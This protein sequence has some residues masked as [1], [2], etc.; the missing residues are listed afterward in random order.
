MNNGVTPAQSINKTT[1]I[2]P[3]DKKPQK[4]STSDVDAFSKA[5]S[6]EGAGSNEVHKAD[7][8]QEVMKSIVDYTIQD[9][10]RQGRKTAKR[11][12]E[13]LRD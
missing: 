5:I 3:L 2:D 7:D 4:A 11:I 9:V 12:K 6:E 10:L 13:S 1:A 8:L